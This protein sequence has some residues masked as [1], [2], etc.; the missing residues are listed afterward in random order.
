MHQD[1]SQAVTGLRDFEQRYTQFQ[2]KVNER[3]EPVFHRELML[4]IWKR[5]DERDQ[6]EIKQATA[7]RLAF[8][9]LDDAYQTLVHLGFDD[10]QTGATIYAMRP[11]DF[12]KEPHLPRGL[13]EYRRAACQSPGCLASCRV[14]FVNVVEFSI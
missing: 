13:G 14:R 11:P 1:R 12:P 6:Q 7:N 2:D 10:R 4:N 3:L 9:E 5:L 8:H